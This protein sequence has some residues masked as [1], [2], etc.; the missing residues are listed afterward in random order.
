MA[1]D[2]LS[3]G[4]EAFRQQKWA[5]AYALL[6]D[7]DRQSSLQPDDLDLGATAAYLVGRDNEGSKLLAREYRARLANSDLPGAAR[8]AI[9]LTVHLMLS[10]EETLAGAWLRRAR[11]VLPGDLDCVE[12]GLLLVPAGLESAARGDPHTAMA[13]FG[14]AVEIGDRFGHQD[15]AALART[16]LS[17]S[18]IAAG[19]PRQAMPLLDDV[20]VSVSANEVSPVISGIV[21]CAVTEACMDAFDLPRAR[22]WTVAFTRWC[23][24][25]PEMVPYQGNCLIH[26]ARI[27]QFQGAW[28]DAFDVAQDARRRLSGLPARPAVG[29]ALY[30]LA[31]LHRLRGELTEARD[32]YLE[33][34]RWVRDPQPGLALL[35]LMQ[36]QK[37]A[38]AA[39]IRRALA[40][41]ES[42]LERARI[43]GAAVEILLAAAD[44]P[45]ARAAAGELR[46]RALEFGG[47]WLH[48]ETRQCDGT[49]LLAD[50]KYAAALEAARQAWSAWQ[51]L[52]A[53][54]ES[55]RARVLMGLAYRGL[56][57]EHAAELEFGAAGWAFHHVGARPDA[58]SVEA[59]THPQRTVRSNPL[60]VRETQVLLL[61]ASGKSNREIAAELFLSEKTVAH[62]TSNIFTKLD[63]T[64]R[65]AATAYAYEHGIIHGS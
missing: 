64:S 12:Q 41:T 18:L 36:G 23:G 19:D 3:L 25:Q 24:S 55:A 15:L 53:P 59:L 21:Y 50:R 14:T 29:A 28:R 33:A 6:S 60:T 47:L 58:A 17:E 32:S 49:L 48:A 10:G 20:M 57:D 51:Q 1:A 45:G 40:E 65:A 16:G 5:D 37:E 61:V 2:P 30:Q 7:A 44:L 43:L 8:S 13:R 39:A 42:R 22:E 46:E 26:R 4:R 63:L 34:S 31:E 38:A 9:W 62:H 52:D 27:M 56:G 11:R 35:F 54:Y